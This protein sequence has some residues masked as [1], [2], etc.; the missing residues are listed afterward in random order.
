MTP[1]THAYVG[2]DTHGTPMLLAVEDGSRDTAQEA[3]RVLAAGGRI[4]RMT[5]DEARAVKL[6]ERPAP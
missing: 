2:Y 3:Q 1:P 6:Y 4:E 5:I